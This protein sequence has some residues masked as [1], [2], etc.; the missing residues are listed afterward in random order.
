MTTIPITQSYRQER[1]VKDDS[2]WRHSVIFTWQGK[3]GE[4]PFPKTL[5][6]TIGGE[7]RFYDLKD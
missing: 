7:T 1:D 3:T 6:L 4:D 5:P 2:K